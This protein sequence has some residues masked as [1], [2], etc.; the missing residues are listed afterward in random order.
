ML[1]FMQKQAPGK[2][3]GYSRSKG[4]APYAPEK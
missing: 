1:P 4:C 3:I 2:A